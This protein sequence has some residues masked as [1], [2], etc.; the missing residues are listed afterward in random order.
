MEKKIFLS[1]FSIIGFC[2]FV[3]FYTYS[4]TSINTKEDNKETI[5]DS[6]ETGTKK[7][8]SVSI[9]D[10]GDSE[11]EDGWKRYVQDTLGISFC[12]PEKWGY[13]YTEPYENITELR[14]IVDQ[15]R[16][17]NAFYE[18]LYIRFSGNP[19]LSIKLFNEQYPGAYYSNARAYHLGYIDN[20]STLKSTG[21]ICRYK[22]HFEWI[23]EGDVMSEI[24]N[25]CSD[26]VK[27]YIVEHD[28]FFGFSGD[29]GPK[30]T[31]KLNLASYTKLENGYFDN[32]LI[33]DQIDYIS[34]I[35]YRILGLDDLLNDDNS[36]VSKEE[37]FVR[38]GDY[39]VFIDSI[40]SFIPASKKIRDCGIVAHEDS[41]IALIH[42]YY[43]HLSNGH[44]DKAFEMK[45][46]DMMSYEEFA[47]R[48]EKVHY[49][50]PRD[51]TRKSDGSYEFFVDY[52]DNNGEVEEYRVVMAAREQ[53]L[54]TLFSELYLSDV[55]ES[56]NGHIA[57]GARRGDKNMMI[58]SI[59]GT[60]V[61]LGEGDAEYD[62][63]HSNMGDVKYFFE[64]QFSES[65]RYFL[66]KM[67]G[68]EWSE[69]R[70]Y[71]VENLEQLA[72]F[73]FPQN[74]GFSQNDTYFYVCAN[75]GI[76]N[77]SYGWVIALPSLERLYDIAND[78]QNIGFHHIDCE[79]DDEARQVIFRGSNI[80]DSQDTHYDDEEF[81]EK[82]F[83]L[84]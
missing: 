54:T 58:L 50:N 35:S 77:P 55:A 25:S 24:H 38:K 44:L 43:C 9:S 5:A 80:Y 72:S 20:I 53:R 10:I 19:G 12:Y 32:A 69:V 13:P 60:E 74:M 31:Y 40:R 47:E 11:C 29:G 42:N 27:E 75:T 83:Y 28:R 48:Y 8:E 73:D 21:D 63:Q 3:F 52:Q 41:D 66:Y 23:S 6:I 2:L 18:S 22:I 4:E 79:Y 65:G 68:W 61:V 26:N 78:T 39:Q 34:Q 76:G 46:P 49:A 45:S 71:D 56:I 70:L 17:H 82:S 33:I 16:E 15:Y 59:D 37:F 62:D 84:E 81:V 14:G 7:K 30:Y 1:F 67:S 57:Y 64:P 36:H 51:F